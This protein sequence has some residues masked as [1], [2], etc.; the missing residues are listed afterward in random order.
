MKIIDYISGLNINATPEEVD[1]VQV[2]SKLLVEEYGYPKDNIKTH[3]QY[4]VK[5]SPSD[6]KK[7][8]PVDIAVFNSSAKNESTIKI[9][10]ECKKENRK[11]GID[12]LQ[13]YLRF[14]RANLGVWFNGRE[15]VFIQKTEK[16]GNTYFRDIPNIPKH[17]ERLEDIGLYRRKDLEAP[18]NLK[19]TFKSVRNFM[20]GN[21]VGTTR[22]EVF[23]QQI[24]NLIF[25]KIYDERFTKPNEMVK[26]RA[27]VGESE[28]EVTRR[29][30]ILFESVKSKYKEVIEETDSIDLDNR[31]L[32][33]IV[34][35]LQRYCLVDAERDVVAE[36]F[37]TFIDHA[38]KGGQGQFF[39]PRNIVKLLVEIVDP[40]EEDL[41]VDPA[42]GSGGFLIE[43]LRH[44]WNKL[45]KKAGAYGWNEMAVA[46]EKKAVAIKNIFGI[47]KDSFL[48]KITKVYMALLG[49][50]KGGIFCEDSLS[51]PREWKSSAK[52][53]IALNKYDILLTNPPFG[54]DI[55]IT[56][57]EK[58]QQFEL[59]HKWITE[60]SSY[61][62]S[63]NLSSSVRPEVLFIERSLQLLKPGG[64][65]AIVLP[66]TFFHAVRSKY[67]IEFIKRHNIK[68]IVDLP[69]NTF[70][71]HNNAKCVAIVLQKDT[72]QD[73]LV[74][75]IVAEQM[76]H[77]HAG[78][79]MFRFD[80]VRERVDKSRLWDDIPSIISEI[81]GESRD[82]K[83]TF[84]VLE[85]DLRKHKVYVPRYYWKGKEKD[86]EYMAEKNGM[87]L[88]S[89]RNLVEE[90]KVSYFD[91]HGS[92]PADYK[93]K[94]NYPY[95]RVSDI[96]NWE[97]YKNPTAK[98]P[99]HIFR[100]YVTDHK[101][102]REGDVLY[103]RRGSYRI[104]SVA[105]A[106]PYDTECLL[107]REIL[108]LRSSG[109][110]GAQPLLPFISSLSSDSPN[111]DIQ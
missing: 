35:E 107:T 102:I 87:T 78:K 44:I 100:E 54:R 13:D 21:A 61:K 92:P 16:D 2:M 99:E 105:I 58:L 37:E 19:I 109:G 36:A 70:R 38:L 56:G 66:E 101:R 7:S 14:S 8:Y 55:K 29:I 27:G 39:T 42:C 22:D 89:M 52:S 104:G 24:I 84:S 57:H 31:T 86:L 85:E 17:G 1:A 98:V 90:G 12:Q 62:P 3:P 28:E 64:V 88:V 18:K 25:C 83:Y 5:A 23:A 45:D 75:L 103:V 10:I 34:G 93:G 9:I 94:G 41:I 51:P 68:W 65:M 63:S 77:D 82:E 72:P 15:R 67:I 106:S 53:H 33:Y 32:V 69:H 26:F 11:D 111:A 50:G 43:S 49:D 4:R 46:E 76:G 96:V 47:E 48:S 110:G 108:I 79:D 91:G 81:R 95:V 71:P 40:S 60:G 73:Y 97:I 30:C 74:N 6:T 20:A 59:A 80:S